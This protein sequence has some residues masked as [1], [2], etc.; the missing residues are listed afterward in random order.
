MNRELKLLLTNYRLAIKNHSLPE[1]YK[2]VTWD[3]I[4]LLLNY[5]EKK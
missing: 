2:S 5:I 1:F 3:K 4:E